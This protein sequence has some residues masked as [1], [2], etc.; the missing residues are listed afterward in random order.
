MKTSVNNNSRP[1]TLWNRTVGTYTR[2]DIIRAAWTIYAAIVRDFRYSTY[3]DD[4]MP[5]HDQRYK[6][7]REA[8]AVARDIISRKGLE[9]IQNDRNQHRERNRV[10]VADERHPINVLALPIVRDYRDNR[11]QL[12]RICVDRLVF[13]GRNHWAKNERDRRVLGIL[14][15]HFNK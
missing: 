11:H 2:R 4:K 8:M 15:A 13:H 12:C 14:A 5:R 7:N 1:A 9:G 3:S 10:K 6:F